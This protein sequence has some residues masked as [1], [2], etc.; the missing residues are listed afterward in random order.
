MSDLTFKW[1]PIDDSTEWARI[2]Q[3]WL[4]HV[5]TRIIIANKSVIS[6]EALQTIIDPEHVMERP[7]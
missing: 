6:S 5:F 4:V 3:G 7:R 2:P 1:E